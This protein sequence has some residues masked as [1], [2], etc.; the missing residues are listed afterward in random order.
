LRR[1]GNHHQRPTALQHRAATAGQRARA[2]RRRMIE[3]TYS[4]Y[5]ADY[6]DAMARATM[7]AAP[8]ERPLA[9]CPPKAK[10]ARSN[11]VGS[12]S[13]SICWTVLSFHGNCPSKRIARIRWGNEAW[14][15]PAHTLHAAP[16]PNPPATSGLI[17]AGAAQTRRLSVRLLSTRIHRAPRSVRPDG[18]GRR[19]AH[20][21][22]RGVPAD[23]PIVR[24]DPV[25]V[26]ISRGL[27]KLLCANAVPVAIHRQI[28]PAN[29]S[30]P[31]DHPS[32]TGRKP[33]SRR[34]G[35]G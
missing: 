24:P 33:R 35:G 9:F 7:P 10:V 20:P 11:R 12:A 14:P 31:V 8:D 23:L 3:R 16:P 29:R 17:S 1:C 4:R 22:V 2:R 6:T 26:A 32:T 28:R 27:G 5:I 15:S 30:H 19:V 25:G 21:L 18:V 13:F 34:H